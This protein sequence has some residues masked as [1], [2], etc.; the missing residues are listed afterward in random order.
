MIVIGV[1]VDKDFRI[2]ARTAA[3]CSAEA[4]RPGIKWG[5]V[6]SREAGVVRST[7]AYKVIKNPDVTHL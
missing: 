4:M 6:A 3:Y 7:F 1:P 5:Y 2:D